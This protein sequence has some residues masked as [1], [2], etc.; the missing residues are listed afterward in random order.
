MKHMDSINIPPE[1][2]KAAPGL[3]GAI[4]ALNWVRGSPMQRIAAFLGGSGSSFWG[5]ETLAAWAHINSGLSGFL[6]GLFG[7]AV[8]GKV[9]EFIQQID[10]APLVQ[11][12]LKKFGL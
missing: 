1:A 7:M 10:I 3:L 8:A 11:R 2:A 9:F 4:V 12:L 6:I 5:S